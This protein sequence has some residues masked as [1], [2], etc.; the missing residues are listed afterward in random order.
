MFAVRTGP[1]D[2]TFAVHIECWGESIMREH[3]LAS[4]Y[5]GTPRRTT[6]P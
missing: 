6:N 5:D 1:S 2:R 4:Q 3:A